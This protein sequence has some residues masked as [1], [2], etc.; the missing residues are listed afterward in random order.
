MKRI[1]IG[2]SGQQPFAITASGVSAIHASLTITDSGE[3]ILRDEDSAN[4]TFIRN[5]SGAFERIE[6]KRI[7][8]N[9]LIRLGDE[10]INGVTFSASQLIQEDPDDFTEQFFAL[11]RTYEQFETEKKRLTHNMRLRGFIPILISLVCF[12]I[13]I[14]FD[15]PYTIRII[16]MLPAMVTPML[17]IFNSKK[18]EQLTEKYATKLVCPKCGKPL[19]KHEITKGICGSCK[20][21][22]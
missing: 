4:G 10:T 5:E 1:V 22:C 3:W 14:P 18:Q 6:V 15:S 7:S 17:G 21:H 20:A 19:S 16:M 2:R 9:T 11:K 13:S 12:A 8:R